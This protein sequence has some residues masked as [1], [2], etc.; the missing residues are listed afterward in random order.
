VLDLHARP[1][2]R[3]CFL[4]IPAAG[5]GE[6]GVIASRVD[7]QAVT[8]LVCPVSLYAGFEEM[9]SL[10]RTTLPRDGRVAMEYVARGLLPTVSRVDAGLI[11]LV[12][13]YGVDVSS[14]A[15][16]ATLE[17]W[18]D[19]QRALHERAARGVDAARRLAL[20]RCGEV[21]GRGE[22]VTEGTLRAVLTA[23]FAGEGLA[24]GDS[25]DVAVNAHAADP[26]YSLDDGEGA[27]ITADSVVLIDLWARVRDAGDA[28]YAD[29]TWMAHTGHTPPA[30]LVRAFAA[31]RAARDAA[32]AAI[33]AAARA[34]TQITGREVDRIARIRGRGG[35]R[36]PSRPPHGAQPGH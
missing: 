10:L 12:R 11:D 6:P 13:S 31:A 5:R 16:I 24:A 14:R 19:R 36:R 30:N 18:N 15:L 32:L 34:G 33:E 9:A 3:R 26:H 35:P 28:P 23:Y 25:P 17:I 22:H 4:W 2:T 29:S 21:L 7:G 1:L 27:A 8:D 20:Q